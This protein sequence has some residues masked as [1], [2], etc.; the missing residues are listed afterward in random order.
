MT[1][2]ANPEAAWAE[3]RAS[4]PGTLLLLV[5]FL[6]IGMAALNMLNGLFGFA[7]GVMASYTPDEEF[8]AAMSG[9]TAVLVGAFNLVFSCVIAAAGWRMRHLESHTLCM[10]GAI[11]AAVPCLSGC[12]CCLVT[13]P[14]GI[15][16][17]QVLRDDMVRAQ[18]H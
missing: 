12:S 4:T 10:A 2:H 8:G 6:S 16:C 1:T 15:W 9:T 13:I 14:V 11:L 3:G 18:F 5:G 17:L 7:D